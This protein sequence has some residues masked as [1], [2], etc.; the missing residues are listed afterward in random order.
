LFRHCV[1][2]LLLLALPA[3]AFAEGMHS[4]DSPGYNQ[5]DPPNTIAFDRIKLRVVKAPML[6]VPESCDATYRSGM[7]GSFRRIWQQC[8]EIGNTEPSDCQRALFDRCTKVAN[9]L[10]AME[11]NA[12]KEMLGEK[13]ALDRILKPDNQKNSQVSTSDL[14]R[15]AASASRRVSDALEKSAGQLKAQ[16]GAATAA[17]QGNACAFSS[18]AVQYKRTET[19]ILSELSKNESFVKA[20]A[21]AKKAAADQFEKVGVKASTSASQMRS[22]VALNPSNATSEAANRDQ[23]TIT[24]PGSTYTVT[25]NRAVETPAV[26]TV[27]TTTTVLTTSVSTSTQTNIVAAPVPPVVLPESKERSIPRWVPILA[28]GVPAAILA[29]LVIS[30]A[31][32][33]NPGSSSGGGDQGGGDGNDGSSSG[34]TGPLVDPTPG[35]ADL[36]SLDMRVDSSFTDA[37]KATIA[38]SVKRIP[39]CYR[40]KLKGLEVRRAN[41]KGRASSAGSCVAGTFTLGSNVVKLDGPGCVGIQVGVTVHEFFHVIGNRNGNALHNRYSSQ[42]VSANPRCP[43]SRYGATNFY[44]DFAE[45]GRIVTVGSDRNNGACVDKKLSGLRQILTSC[46]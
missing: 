35:G 36:R 41:L 28:I 20:Q 15:R 17:L 38:A 46:Q 11:V 30:K 34:S 21:D 7:E 19:K 40:Y 43:V 37:E 24:G 39:E 10:Q 13:D 26:Q 6:Q 5:V 42:V 18:A 27:V 32:K 22:Q 1:S 12:C 16:R 29:G 45:A 14:N 33:S 8:Q 4:P 25:E 3:R 23:S 2:I 31:S 44:E 9:E